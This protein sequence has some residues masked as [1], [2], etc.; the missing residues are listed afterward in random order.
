M[1]GSPAGGLF[2]PRVLG[3]SPTSCSME[4]MLV[5]RR[6]GRVSPAWGEPE[7]LPLR[8]H[9]G[10]GTTKHLCSRKLFKSPFHIT[11]P[12]CRWI[13]SGPEQRSSNWVTYALSAWSEP[14]ARAFSSLSC[15][16]RGVCALRSCLSCVP[17]GL[18]QC[19]QTGQQQEPHASAGVGPSAQAQEAPSER[20]TSPLGPPGMLRGGAC[21]WGITWPLCPWP[22]R[23]GLDPEQRMPPQPRGSWSKSGPWSRHC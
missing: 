3:Y 10:P 17:G 8:P 11:G 20:I 6:E 21:S 15:A 16:S 18:T 12:F 9:G 1:A 13:N 4:K 2:P 19:G 22:Q 14:E 5:A 23:P 7:S